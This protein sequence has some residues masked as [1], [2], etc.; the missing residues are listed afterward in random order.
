MVKG[1]KSKIPTDPF[2]IVKPLKIKDP[3]RL[4]P[5]EELPDLIQVEAF[6]PSPRGKQRIGRY[7]LRE[8][9]QKF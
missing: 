3:E 8:L 1:R 9:Y 6:M 7:T 4:P 5:L 2:F